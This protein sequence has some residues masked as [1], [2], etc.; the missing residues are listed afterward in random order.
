MPIDWDKELPIIKQSATRY[1]VDWKIIAAI[2]AAENGGE[3]VEFGVKSISAPT[4]QAQLEAACVSVRN[5]IANDRGGFL[6]VSKPAGDGKHSALAINPNWVRAFANHWAPEGAADDPNHLNAN[7]Y[8]NF[9]SEYSRFW[10]GEVAGAGG[11]Q[12]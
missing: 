10:A 12:L 2:R 6:F 3:G 1:Q 11:A 4:Y 9:M 7:W 8:R 5:H